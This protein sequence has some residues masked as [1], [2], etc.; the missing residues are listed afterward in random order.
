MQSLIYLL[1]VVAYFYGSV[2]FGLLTAK[3]FKGVDIRD[4]GSGNIGATNAARV[5]GWK[6][7]PAVFLL[8]FSK[9]FVP[10]LA[11]VLL[12]AEGAYDPSLLAV[13]TALAAVLG[14]VFPIYIGFKG[15]KAVATGSGVF[16]V[17]APWCVAICVAVWGVMFAVWRYVSLASISAAGALIVSAWLLTED[18]T[19]SGLFLSIFATAGGLMV[20]ALHHGNIGRLLRGEEHKIGERKGEEDSD[21]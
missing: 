17:L 18:P 5:L 21:A 6:F 15:G 20:I 2:P 13:V 9:G 11:A 16:L 19:G 3:A 14:H 12:T 10:T 4:E 8:D 1:P 7:F